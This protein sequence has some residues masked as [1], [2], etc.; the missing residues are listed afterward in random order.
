MENIHPQ[1][2]IGLGIMNSNQKGQVLIYVVSLLSFVILVI[3][4][5]TPL[6]FVSIYRSLGLASSGKAFYGAQ[7]GVQEAMLDLFW[8]RDFTGKTFDLDGVTVEII[9]SPAGGGY[10]DY[11]SLGKYQGKIRRVIGTF[12]DAGTYIDMDSWE[13]V[14]VD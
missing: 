4:V 8:D 10:Y 14:G 11:E 1:G 12:R 6:I 5:A 13:E 9:V 7:S 3:G 2:I